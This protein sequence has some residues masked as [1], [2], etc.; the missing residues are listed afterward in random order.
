[1]VAAVTDEMA[2]MRSHRH[3]DRRR[4]TVVAANAAAAAA[5]VVVVVDDADRVG[6][7]VFAHGEIL[8]AIPTAADD[9]LRSV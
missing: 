7:Q 9:D 3:P 8:V 6:E 5:I 4:V 2:E 1:M